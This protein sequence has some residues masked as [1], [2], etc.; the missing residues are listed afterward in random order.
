MFR[1]ERLFLSIARLFAR[2]SEPKFRFIH[3]TATKL[4]HIKR[5]VSISGSAGDLDIDYYALVIATG[6]STPSPLYGLNQDA[7]D[8]RMSWKIFRKALLTVKTIVIAGAGP[9]G[10]ETAA[11]LGEWLN[12]HS[13]WYSYWCGERSFRA[14]VRSKWKELGRESAD[15]KVSITVVAAGPQILPDLSRK[16][17]KKAERY[18]AKLGVTVIKNVRVKSVKPEG[19]GTRD[20]LTSK[21]TVTLEDGK[22]LEADLY[23]PAMGTIPNTRFVHKSLLTSKG[24]VENNPMTLRVERAGSLVYAVGD[25]ASY[26]HPSIHL[27]FRAIPVLCHNLERDLYLATNEGKR[28]APAKDLIFTEHGDRSHLVVIGR[29]KGVG[30]THGLRNWPNTAVW[31]V[32]GKSYY[33]WTTLAVLSG[34]PWNSSFRHVTPGRRGARGGGAE[35]VH[36]DR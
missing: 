8:L 27:I 36:D 28:L 25:V 23:I 22:T 9:A 13:S 12:S 30:A 33:T 31:L 5:I 7:E 24:L 26:S 20:K 2:Y 35:S 4:D 32:K 16:L 18:L 19:A 3:G 14:R 1:Q 10:V 11:E 15:P 34:I 21:T 6:A 17:A 29:S